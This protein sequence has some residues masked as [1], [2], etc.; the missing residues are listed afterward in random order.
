MIVFID[1]SNVNGPDSYGAAPVTHLYLKVSEGTGFVDSTY[2]DRK[3]QGVKAKAKVGG[4]HFA[5]HGDPVA[6]ADFFLARVGAGDMRPCLDLESGQS[7]L[8]ASAFVQRV[9][10]KLGYYPVLYGSTSFIGPMRSATALLRHPLAARRIR[11]CPWWRAE[12]GS[13][14]GARHALVG[15]DQG[16]VAHQYTSTAVVVGISGHTDRSAIMNEAALMRPEPKPRWNIT[17]DGERKKSGLRPFKVKAWEA[18]H[19]RRFGKK[20][21]H[22]HFDRS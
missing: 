19:R 16:A 15:G 4:Y 22:V 21:N 13:N 20:H 6:E 10:Q 7:I 5:G 9:K 18:A 17:M 2:L 12:F 3:A 14:D 8:W 1:R 11:Q